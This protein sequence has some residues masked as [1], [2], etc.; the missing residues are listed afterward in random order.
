MVVTLL[1]NLFTGEIGRTSV[2]FPMDPL[3]RNLTDEIL[4]SG[5][6][7]KCEAGDIVLLLLTGDLVTNLLLS[8]AFILRFLD[9]NRED[10]V[11]SNLPSNT[12]NSSDN[13]WKSDW[14]D[15]RIPWAFRAPPVRTLATDFIGTSISSAAPVA[16]AVN[17]HSNF[18]LNPLSLGDFRQR[19]ID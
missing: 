19:P 13:T 11:S 16:G 7:W 1:T 17:S 2:T 9:T 12:H 18:F 6:T 5:A 10:G 8:L 15:L 3:A 4:S 14:V